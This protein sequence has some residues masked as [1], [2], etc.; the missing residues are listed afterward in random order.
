MTAPRLPQPWPT[1]GARVPTAWPGA[2]APL[3]PPAAAAA[4]P[5]EP[6]RG[7]K[8]WVVYLIAVLLLVGPQW[9]VGGPS[10]QLLTL[11]TVGTAVLLVVNPPK[12]GWYLPLLL[13]FAYNILTMPLAVNRLYAIVPIKTLFVYYVFALATI[14]FIRTPK[15][16]WPLLAIMFVWQWVW[17]LGWGLV[18]GQVSWHPE[19]ANHDAFGP[20]MVI[21]SGMCLYFA[22]AV[23][24]KWLR[25]L[26]YVCA[27]LCVGGVVSAFARGAVLTLALVLVV[28]W[29]R[30]PRKG[31]MTAAMVLMVGAIVLAAELLGSTTRSGDLERGP[32]TFWSEM[33]TSME[34]TSEGTGSDRKVLWTLAW[35]LFKSSPIIGVGGA[36]FGPASATMLRSVEIGGDYAD[37]QATLYDRAL[38]NSLVQVLCEYGTIGSLIFLAMLV[39]F[40]IRNRQLRRRRLADAWSRAMGGTVDLPMLSLGLESGMV[41]Y[42]GTALFY[43]QL[44]VPWLYTLLTFNVMLHLLA[45]RAAKVLGPAP[46]PATMP[47]RPGY[48]PVPAAR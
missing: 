2:A 3:P 27:V 16:A 9:F 38:H 1:H 6:K 17:W 14:S 44:F 5:P 18:P 23:R 11:V 41:A 19:L 33:A 43:N 48:L 35:G 21:G 34:G 39:D 15:E 46:A 42:L 47:V 31:R 45:K 22:Q 36:N 20:L 25:T 26:G 40:A 7:F 32:T 29:L 24:V 12:R 13:F 37:N 28:A 30:S 4:A 8:Q 10:R